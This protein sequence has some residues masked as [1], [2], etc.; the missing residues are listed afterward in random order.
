MQTVNNVEVGAAAYDLKDLFSV[1]T[2]SVRK[3]RIVKY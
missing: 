2:A 3:S 1:I